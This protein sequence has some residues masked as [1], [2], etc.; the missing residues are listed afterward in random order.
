MWPYWVSTSGLYSMIG[1]SFEFRFS[2]INIWERNHYSMWTWFK[3]VHIREGPLSKLV[4]YMIT[5]KI[6]FK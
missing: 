2:H 6:G 3:E 1:T 4:C 5:A